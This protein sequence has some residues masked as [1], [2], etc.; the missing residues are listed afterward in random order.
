MQAESGKEVERFHQDKEQVAYF[1]QSAYLGLPKATFN[2]ESQ[3]MKIDT[4]FF[5]KLSFKDAKE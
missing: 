3:C 1:K 4:F 2:G 5:Q